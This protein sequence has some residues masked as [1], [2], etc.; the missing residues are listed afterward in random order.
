MAQPALTKMKDA[1][2]TT[3]WLINNATADDDQQSAVQETPG[4]EEVSLFIETTAKNGSPTNIK[5][6]VDSTPDGTYWMKHVDPDDVEL[7]YL[8]MTSFTVNDRRVVRFPLRS[9]KWRI[10][11]VNDST[12]PTNNNASFQIYQEKHTPSQRMVI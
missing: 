3:T 6:Y 11:L 1:N 9:A 10:R 12:T 2:G 5:L 8:T 7:A 4:I